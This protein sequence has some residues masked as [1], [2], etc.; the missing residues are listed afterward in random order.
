MFATSIMGHRQ[1]LILL[2]Y[3]FF[4]ECVAC[5][6]SYKLFNYLANMN[7]QP[8]FDAR[9]QISLVESAEKMSGLSLHQMADMIAD[10]TKKLRNI[11]N[12]NR[13]KFDNRPD[14]LFLQQLLK[15][16]LSVPDANG[17]TI[18]D[19]ERFVRNG[20]YFTNI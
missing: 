7:D 6:N 13:K 14:V 10:C 2:K 20:Q 8:A 16:L 3:G 5:K 1:G 11:D 4:C 15:M 12:A 18:R 19:F 9:I 17:L